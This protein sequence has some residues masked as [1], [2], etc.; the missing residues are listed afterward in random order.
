M[1]NQ[2]KFYLRKNWRVR[3]GVSTQ[4]ER[5]NLSPGAENNQARKNNFYFN[6]NK[7]NIPEARCENNQSSYKIQVSAKKG[8]TGMLWLDLAAEEAEGSKYLTTAIHCNPHDPRR[9]K[10]I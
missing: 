9:S 5:L 8:E 10:F 2:H 4:S 3:Y 6:L 7:P 1:S